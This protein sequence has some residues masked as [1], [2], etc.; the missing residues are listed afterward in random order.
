M[1]NAVMKNKILPVLL[2]VFLLAPVSALAES[3]NDMAK[4]LKGI[5]SYKQTYFIGTNNYRNNYAKVYGP[6]QGSKYV[7]REIKF[8]LS[9]QWHYFE[10]KSWDIG[11]SYTQLSYWQAL[12]KPISNPFRETNYEPEFIFVN[13]RPTSR[14]LQIPNPFGLKT[15]YRFAPLV[16]H[17]NGQSGTTSRSW[18]YG[19]L[20]VQL[21][22]ENHWYIGLK[23]KVRYP[24]KAASD[25]N[26]DIT[27][28][29][30]PL[31]LHARYTYK[32]KHTLH[33]M[34]RNNLR[35]DENRG[36]VQLDYSYDWELLGDIDLYLQAFYGYGESLIEHD[37]LNTRY[38]AGLILANW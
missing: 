21:S 36:A 22:D 1:N 23:G 20:E 18:N 8:Q 14:L 13:Y 10:G 38:G 15:S 31:E 7:Q 17:S 6:V 9:F 26:P 35:V 25:D 28:Y 11:S 4:I 3:G 29:Y 24:E 33:L 2:L 37:Q 5:K 34:F 27:K 32:K 30:G 12:N 16:H 19:Y